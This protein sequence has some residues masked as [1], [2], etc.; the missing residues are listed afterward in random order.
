MRRR[1]VRWRMFWWMNASSRWGT[2]FHC[3]YAAALLRSCVASYLQHNSLHQS[4]GHQRPSRWVHVKCIRV[5]RTDRLLS[6]TSYREPAKIHSTTSQHDK[7]RMQ[8][9]D[10]ERCPPVHKSDAAQP[11]LKQQQRTRTENMGQCF[12]AAS[13][14]VVW[15]YL[16]S[17][18]L[19]SITHPYNVMLLMSIRITDHSAE[20]S[21]G[22]RERRSLGAAGAG[23]RALPLV[24][25]GQRR[26]LLPCVVKSLQ[27]CFELR[28]PLL[29]R[30]DAI[31]LQ[32]AQKGPFKGCFGST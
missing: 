9:C 21:K 6:Q 12:T 19:L 28:V 3:V 1:V 16:C 31:N 7:T 27:R 14:Q 30:R 5:L 18:S 23:C 4:T 2:S 25:D 26:L 17:Q 13:G 11:S 15:W 29:I 20:Q 24:D 8:R 22:G 32:E 10:W